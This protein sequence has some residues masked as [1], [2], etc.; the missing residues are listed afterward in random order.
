[1][2]GRHHARR[3]DRNLISNKTSNA[4]HHCYNGDLPVAIRPS[5]EVLGN[6]VFRP[7]SLRHAHRRQVLRFRVLHVAREE[8]SAVVSVRGGTERRDV[9]V[10]WRV[11]RPVGRHNR[12]RRIS[13]SYKTTR[14]YAITCV[15]FIFSRVIILNH[16][17]VYLF[18]RGVRKREGILQEPSSLPTRRELFYRRDKIIRRTNLIYN[19][20]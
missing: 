5:R 8:E 11:W 7:T 20:S 12:F 10:V 17:L 6:A 18:R 3:V 15:Q 14:R 13:P 9:T 2:L 16:R 4:A 1:M 19:W